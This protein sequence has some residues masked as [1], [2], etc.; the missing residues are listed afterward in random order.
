MVVAHANSLRSILMYLDKLTAEEVMSIA[1]F[2]ISTMH[3]LCMLV[4]FE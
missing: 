2:L 1:F 3:F 4:G